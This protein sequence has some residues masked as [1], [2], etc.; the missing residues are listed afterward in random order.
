M[1]R[2]RAAPGRPGGAAVHAAAAGTLTR[3]RLPRRGPAGAAALNVRVPFPHGR[4]AAPSTALPRA[5]SEG[6]TPSSPKPA[7]VSP[8]RGETHPC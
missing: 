8:E 3:L 7:R 1:G 4:P 6:H 2:G 5:R